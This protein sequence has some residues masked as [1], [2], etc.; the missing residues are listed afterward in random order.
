MS[1]LMSIFLC[2]RDNDILF[3]TR[4]LGVNLSV[5]EIF[6][7][8]QRFVVALG[9]HFLMSCKD[10]GATSD[11]F[12][13]TSLSCY[14]MKS[15]VLFTCCMFLKSFFLFKLVVF[16]VVVAVKLVFR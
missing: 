8:H 6:R 1:L 16:P 4:V 9:S 10:I 15:A 7:L 5:C 13:V 2:F 3:V 11:Y 12:N 14:E